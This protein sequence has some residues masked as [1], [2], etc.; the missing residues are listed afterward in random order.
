MGSHRVLAP[1]TTAAASDTTMFAY[2]PGRTSSGAVRG[3]RLSAAGWRLLGLLA[4]GGAEFGYH[5]DFAW[6]DVRIASAVRHRVNWQP[7]RYD[8]HSYEAADS[9]VRLPAC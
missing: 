7:W 3:D 8:H 6:G 2:L 9:A 4:A 1:L 5:G